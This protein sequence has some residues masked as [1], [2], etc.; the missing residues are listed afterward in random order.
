MSADWT[1]RCDQD[2]GGGEKAAVE[3]ILPTGSLVLCRHH[4]EANPKLHEYPVVPCSG[5]PV[6]AGV[7]G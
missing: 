5:R 2:A 7:V 1:D 4:Y 3:V 6:S